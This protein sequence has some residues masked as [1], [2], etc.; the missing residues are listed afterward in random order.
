MEQI[1]YETRQLSF[2]DIKPKRKLRYDEI[3][4]ILDNREM[5][6]KEIAVE[7]FEYGLIPSTE[8]NFTA[9]RLNE[10]EKEGRVAIIGKKKCDWTGK[11][12]SV[13]KAINWTET[14]LNQGHVTDYGTNL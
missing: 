7:L 9:P 1:A 13:Y 14:G 3:L 12:V 4:G 11:M 8:R 10:L 6:A 5:T 2:A